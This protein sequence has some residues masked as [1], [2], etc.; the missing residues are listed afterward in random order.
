MTTGSPSQH[1][2]EAQKLTADALVDLYEI[3]LN[4]GTTNLRFTN[5]KAVTWQTKTY[6]ALACRL[7]GL[8]H[9]ADGAKSRPLL[10]VMNPEGVWNSFVHQGLLESASVVRRQVLRQY[11]ESNVGVSDNNFWYVSRVKE[12]IRNQGITFELRA[13]TDGPDVKIPA[14]KYLPPAFPFVTI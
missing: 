5:G 14:R 7:T 8:Q 6:E 9:S 13:L 11:L 2:A 1:V 3:T 10:T 12:L 4:D